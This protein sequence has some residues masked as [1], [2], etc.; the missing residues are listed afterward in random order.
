MFT[1]KPGVVCFA[2]NQYR[3]DYQTCSFPKVKNG[4]SCFI[5]RIMHML[6]S[7]IKSLTF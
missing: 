7:Q 5:S 4:A 6:L 3:D 1:M 2:C